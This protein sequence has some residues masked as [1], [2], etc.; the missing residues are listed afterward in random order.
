MNEAHNLDTQAHTRTHAHTY[1]LGVSTRPRNLL[2]VCHVHVADGD[3]S[4]RHDL[5]QQAAGATIDVVS[6]HNVL[7]SLDQLAHGVKGSHAAGEGKATVASL[8]GSHLLLQQ[9][10]A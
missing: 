4:S 8:K 6:S 7:A 2:E 9:R 10:P 1:T 5:G 3:T